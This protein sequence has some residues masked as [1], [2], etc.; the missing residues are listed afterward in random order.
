MIFMKN[1]NSC[2]YLQ[3]WYPDIYSFWCVVKIFRGVYLR[4]IT[5]THD[6][7]ISKILSVALP[8][9]NLGAFRGP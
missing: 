8:T 6:L 9:V 3:I 4:G 1:V 2:K 7:N 5:W